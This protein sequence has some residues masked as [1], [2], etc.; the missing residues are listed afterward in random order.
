MLKKIQINKGFCKNISKSIS[1]RS[2]I[3]IVLAFLL[4]LFT[5]NIGNSQALVEDD[6][7]FCHGPSLSD[8]HHWQLNASSNCTKCHSTIP[9][10]K[11]KIEDCLVCHPIT[12][13]IN[14]GNNCTDC[15]MEGGNYTA[16]NRNGSII[17]KTGFINSVHY[18]I[19]GNFSSSNYTEISKVCWGCHVNYTDQL[20]NPV[21]SKNSSQLPSCEDCHDADIPL[22]S[23]NLR[24][25]PIQ[26]P[27]HQPLGEDVQ[28]DTS[29]SCSF[30]HNNSLSIP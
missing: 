9:E 7:R 25:N 22:N 24:I 20:T 5:A 17:S 28:T 12:A 21:H 15:H 16:L 2:N 19:T 23:N 4:I 14:H 8:T 13:K 27:E 3:F 10:E 6:C 26:I 11:L 18:N 1:M 30:C 29:T